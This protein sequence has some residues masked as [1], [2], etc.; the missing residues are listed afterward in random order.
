MIGHSISKGL[1]NR[2]TAAFTLAEVVVSTAISA[3]VIGGIAYGYIFSSKQAEWSAYSLAAQSLAIQRMEQARAANWDPLS[4]PLIDELVST[5]FPPVTEI[6]D[7][8]RSG[9]NLVYATNLTTITL[10]S[11]NPPLKMIRVECVWPYLN[12]GF[13]TNSISAYRAPDE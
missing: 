5:N 6:L 3:L 9:T 13:F 4:S 10:I 2:A 11:T 7:I 12:R 8:P 1:S